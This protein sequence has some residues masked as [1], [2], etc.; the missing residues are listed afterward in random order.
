VSDAWRQNLSSK[1]H[2]LG[3]ITMEELNLSRC[4]KK[5]FLGLTEPSI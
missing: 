5:Y 4:P 3:E 2:G 1:I